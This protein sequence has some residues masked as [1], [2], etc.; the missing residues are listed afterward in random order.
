MVE[1][2][3]V[4]IIL[5]ILQINQLFLRLLVLSGMMHICPSNNGILMLFPK[6]LSPSINRVIKDLL[7]G[8]CGKN[9]NLTSFSKFLIL[10]VL[11]HAEN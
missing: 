11:F 7:T 1:V 2:V 5:I 3:V 10:W 8:E 6:S 9:M 4:G